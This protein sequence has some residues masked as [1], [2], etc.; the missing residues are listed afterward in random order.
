M[1]PQKVIV[2]G[3]GAAGL[4]AAWT[5]KKHGINVILFEASDQIGGRMGGDRVDGFSLDSAADFFPGS[6]DVAFRVCEELGLPLVQTGMNIGWYRNGRWVVTKA[7]RSVDALVS[8]LAATRSLGILSFRGLL[9]TMKMIKGFRDDSEYLNYKSDHRIAELDGEETYGEYLDRLGVPKSLRV[10]MEGFLELTMGHVEEFGATW[11]RVFLAEVLLKPNELYVPEGGCSSVTYTMAAELGDAI[12]LSTPV[13]RVII[14]DGVATGVITD[15]EHIDADAVICA[16]PA[17]KALT[18][19]PD[20]SPRVRNALGKVAYSRGIR[21]VIGLNHRAL[22][23]GWHV[24]LYPEDNTPA[25]LDRTIN[26]PACAP[27]G[28]ST[29]DL[30][31]GRDRADEL[32]PLD[33]EEIKHQM[34]RDVRR[35]PPPG[36]QL[37]GDDEG[38]FTRVYRWHEAVCKGEPGMFKAIVD[39]RHQLPQDTKNFFLAGDYMRSPIVNGALAS[40][41][42]AANEIASMLTSRDS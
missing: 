11:V 35:N 16:T 42:D 6:Y 1:K 27:P 4:S 5:L 9:A 10:T 39:M 29:L 14:R 23:A 26:L 37:P 31:V 33:D 20:L 38:L 25:M 40:G 18:L 2:I 13:R 36:S 12:R 15:D 3:G 21:V 19:T 8:N 24:A 34:L 28:K 17:T 32:L 22:P 30:W 41:V 7:G